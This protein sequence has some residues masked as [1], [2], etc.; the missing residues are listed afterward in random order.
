MIRLLSLCMC[1]LSL[2]GAFVFGSAKFPCFVMAAIFGV[3]FVFAGKL[4]RKKFFAFVFG[5]GLIAAL[6]IALM[7]PA[8]TVEGTAAEY[9]SKMEKAVAYLEKGKPESAKEEL[10]YLREHYPQTDSL[11]SV[12][13]IYYISTGDVEEAKRV[14]DYFDNKTCRGYFE[15]REMCMLADAE[16]YNDYD[17]CS[18]YREAADNNPDW[19]Y[20]NLYAGIYLINLDDY[21]RAEYYL[22][23]AYDCEELTY[24]IPYY[25]G[26][27]C[28][29]QGRMDEGISYF[30][31]SYYLGAPDEYVQVMEFYLSRSKKEVGE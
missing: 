23:V 11:R 10:D 16:N 26:L 25:L 22:R 4:V 19:A 3:L 28:C 7:V 31:E 17:F 5:L 24:D 21:P 1:I 9:A 13:V 29:D 12:E 14:I 30:E 27:I 15:A 6:T 20:A 2:L 18:L 8:T